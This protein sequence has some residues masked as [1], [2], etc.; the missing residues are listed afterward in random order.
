MRFTT[1]L[2]LAFV[3]TISLL[4]L[5]ENLALGQTT[6][7]G[8]I[9]GAVEDPQHRIVVGAK[10]TATHRGTNEAHSV[11]TNQMGDYLI[12]LL[13][14]GEYKLEIAQP[15]FANYVVPKV[16]V[17][18]TEKARVDV[19]LA[20]QEVN[21]TVNVSGQGEMVQHDSSAGNVISQERIVGLPLATRNYTQL[22]VLS[23][24][25]AADVPNA[26]ALGLNSV[27][28]SAQGGRKTDNSVQ[29]NGINAMNS[30]TNTVGSYFGGQ[31]VAVPAADSIEEFK[32]QTAQY[33]AT[34][35]GGGGA[36]VAVITKSGT[37]Q[38]RGSVYEYF[39][40]DALNA[41]EYFLKSN[42]QPRPVLKQNQFGFSLGAPIQKDK[43]FIFG[44]YQGTRQ[45]NGEAPGTHSTVFLPPQ[46]TDNRSA[47][48]LGAAFGG[49]KGFQAF[50][51]GGLGVAVAPNGSNI[52]PV[53]LAILN[54][55]L[56]DGQYVL[57]TPH[58]A[59]GSV[60]ID[61]PGT[62]SE[63]QF[64]LNLDR[65]LGN[66]GKLSSRYFYA[67]SLSSIPFYRD[68]LPG[69]GSRAP[70]RNHNFSLGYTKFLNTTMTNVVR[71]GY[72]RSVNHTI[73]SDPFTTAQVGMT[74]PPQ[75][76]KLPQ[77]SVVGAWSMG[78]GS[79][80]ETGIFTDTYDVGDTLSFLKGR[81]FIQVGGQ[82]EHVR[83]DF[84]FRN[85]DGGFVYML[86]FPSFLLGQAAGANGFIFSHV[87]I[88]AAFSGDFSRDDRI[89][90]FAWF[91]Q[92]DI[93]VNSRLNLN[94]GLRYDHFG[95]FQDARHRNADFDFT[96][97]NT[98]IP[99]GATTNSGHVIGPG[100]PGT[101]PSDVHV[102]EDGTLRTNK[103]LKD[104]QPR[105]GFALQPLAS[106]KNL[107][108]RGG[109]GIFYT[110]RAGISVFMHGAGYPYN[111]F[112]F[113]QLAAGS[114]A[115]LQNPLPPIA[116]PSAFP[117]FVPRSATSAESIT[118][119]DLRMSDPYTQQY[120]LAARG[121]SS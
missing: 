77:V 47:S 64:T 109:Y 18:V 55:K 14:V 70:A 33:G 113:N 1:A 15:G 62:F 30:Y 61:I 92:D 73:P 56:P 11:L 37:N 76:T 120:S 97:A 105:I 115:T 68:S 45:T 87:A 44:A 67:S 38:V 25:V 102:A 65:D 117:L 52:N 90:N 26:V 13:P 103:N 19:A 93:R 100:F 8:A 60:E 24:G 110:N 35:A 66:W 6:T 121:V 31:G 82:V 98:D 27:E 54:L 106:S 53:A 83:G 88:N 112:A 5:A 41:N 39:R 89:N 40:N 9:T 43:F 91:V 59:N 81:H 75:V 79:V 34:T 85:F 63:N 21:V 96:L 50:A 2:K 107:V 86:D 80:N 58:S 4:L 94:L 32:V 10:V 72:T 49:Q 119:W 114:Q 57:P 111:A 29:I 118:A 48:A 116:P 22:M 78:R 36:A 12:P 108:V 74:P 46:L 71:L 16:I 95:G 99:A 20:V 69:F 23:P 7:T 17:R 3:A 42:N 28:F 84:Q 51:P 101:V 104:F